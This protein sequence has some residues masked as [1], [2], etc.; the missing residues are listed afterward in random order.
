MARRW[1]QALAR[2][3]RQ[4]ARRHAWLE[5]TACAARRYQAVRADRLAAALA[6][7]AFFAVFALTGI[8]FAVLGWI[9]RRDLAA[10][11]LAQR[12]VDRNLPGLDVDELVAASGRIGVIALVGLLVA[13]WYW[14]DGLRGAVRTVWRLESR[15]GR[16]LARLGIDLLV[17]LAFGLLLALSVAVA[18]GV[19][20][21]VRWMVVDAAG[22]EGRPVRW[23]IAV[24]GFVLGIAVNTV[25]ATALLT[26]L[27]RLTMP[28]RRVLGPAL[29][30]AVALELLKTVGRIYFERTEANPAYHAVASA[31]G[32]LLF[33]NL[34]NQAVL[35]A[36]ALT[37]TSERGEAADLANGGTPATSAPT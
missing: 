28:L 29:L 16:F 34:L 17:L 18:V 13:G 19:S 35:F 21:A 11:Q 5:H 2:R 9:V 37:A 32:L 33:L 10:I 14:V 25:L 26:G 15:P 8:A 6:Y 30:V 7:Y 20:S 36:A 24:L 12:W 1:R 3:W 27:P 22:V 23:L 4:A 31:V